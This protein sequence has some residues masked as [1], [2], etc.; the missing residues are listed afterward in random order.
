MQED[1]TERREGMDRNTSAQDKK[2]WRAVVNMVM[3]LWLPS[4]NLLIEVSD[5]LLNG[6]HNMEAIYIT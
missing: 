5:A 2:Q 1:R 3:N 4:L 6:L